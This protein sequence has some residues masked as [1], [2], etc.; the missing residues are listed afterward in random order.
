MFA[1]LFP[2]GCSR[3]TVFVSYASEQR[4]LG[5]EIAQALKNAGHDVFFDL[6]SIPGGGNFNDSIRGAILSADR[7]VFLASRASVTP[8]KFT[9]TELQF[10]KERW[11]SPASRVFPVLVDDSLAVTELPV[12]LKSVSVMRT[13]GNATAEVV[14][15]VEKTRRVGMVCRVVTGLALAGGIAGATLALGPG[16]P[17]RTADVVLLPPQKIH[18][19]S[20]AEAPLKPDAPGANAEWVDTPMTITV[21][22]VAFTHRTEPGRRV[23]ILAE[24]LEFSYAGATS[25][26][27]ALYVV[28]ITDQVCGD[29]WYCIKGN[30]GPETLEPGRSINRETMFI[31]VASSRAITW[32]TFVDD[33]LS[34]PDVPVAVTY[35]ASVEVPDWGGAK[36]V[37][38]TQSCRIDTATV[39]ADLLAAKFRPGD[40]VKPVFL[41]P[42]CLPV[43]GAAAAEAASGAGKTK[44]KN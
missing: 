1:R 23:R 30:A 17:G 44:S 39:K 18:F 4:A 3:L 12:Y 7:M 27:R 5:E 10:A 21:M 13:S 11:P 38:M 20:Q 16:L 22:P 36:V 32:R 25:T 26:Y 42:D 31:P 8:G 35:R 40:T 43:T 34:K 14:A 9:M 29:R 6:D 37:A 19:R 24:T 33:I 15:A 28:E 2:R 41:E